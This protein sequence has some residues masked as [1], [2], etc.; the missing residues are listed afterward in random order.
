MRKAKRQPWSI[1]FPFLAFGFSFFTP[2]NTF[3]SL[4]IFFRLLFYDA[5]V[6]LASFCGFLHFPNFS[7]CLNS[8]FSKFPHILQVSRFRAVLFQFYIFSSFSVFLCCS[9]MCVPSS[10]L[11]LICFLQFL[12]VFHWQFVVCP[13][14]LWFPLLS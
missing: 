6:F 5:V 9:S 10:L 2:R 11:G 3:F 4:L 8:G 14:F 13:G 7:R 1:W 12:I